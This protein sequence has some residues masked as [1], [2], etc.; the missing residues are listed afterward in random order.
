MVL[1]SRVEMVLRHLLSLLLSATASTG[2]L[3][4]FLL[5]LHLDLEVLHVL[6][7]LLQMCC[8]TLAVSRKG[9]TRHGG[10]CRHYLRMQKRRGWRKMSIWRGLWS[11]VCQSNR[12]LKT[13]VLR[14]RALR[15]R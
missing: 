11:M 5:S 7:I 2:T 1:A 8:Q 12:T 4:A 14:L 10:R 3:L 13:L 9:W 15:V 6:V